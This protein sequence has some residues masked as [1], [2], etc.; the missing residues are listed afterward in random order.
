MSDLEEGM[1]FR[2]PGQANDLAELQRTSTPCRTCAPWLRKLSHRLSACEAELE[3][4]N[5][6]IKRVI[7]PVNDA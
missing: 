4:C 3:K 5:K 6:K 7:T 1:A 2:P